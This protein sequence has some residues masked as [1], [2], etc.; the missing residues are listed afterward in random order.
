MA[1]LAVR[2]LQRYSDALKGLF[3]PTLS[4]IELKSGHWRVDDGSS[5]VAAVA[6]APAGGEEDDDDDGPQEPP[7]PPPPRKSLSRSPAS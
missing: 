2:S 1:S 4:R 7:P 5:V 6:S 3:A